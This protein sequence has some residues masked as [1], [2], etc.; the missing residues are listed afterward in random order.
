MRKSLRVAFLVALVAVVF[1]LYQSRH[2]IALEGFH[3]DILL[4]SLREA[5]LRLLLLSIAA[6]FA[7]YAVRALRWNRLSRKV[8]APSFWGTYSATLMG[9]TCLFLFGRL[10]EPLRPLLIARKEQLPVTGMFGVYVIERLLDAAS[11]LVIGGIALLIFQRQNVAGDSS[12]SLMH[13]ARHGGAG[14]LIALVAMIAILVYFRLHGAGRLAGWLERARAKRGVAGR[15]AA[16]ICSFSE[17]LQG[18][19]SGS[20]LFFA[21][22]YTALHWLLIA[23]IYQWVSN[24]FGDS[25]GSLTLAGAMLVLAFTMVG[26]TAQLPAVGGGAQLASFLVFTAILGVE[27]ERAAVA[28]ITIWLISFAVCSIVGLPLLVREGWSLGELRQLARA[29]AVAKAEGRHAPDSGEGQT[30]GESRQ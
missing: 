11:T 27:R 22:F 28:A 16:L 2:A 14:L 20:D 29:E 30:R 4:A 18:I 8:G 24:S 21:V 9:F 12:S 23:L 15:F 17:G 13:R 26:S 3:W 10:G 6:I 5:N 1:L 25:L 19:Q 7:A